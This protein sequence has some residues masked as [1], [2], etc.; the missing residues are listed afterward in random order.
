MGDLRRAR[1]SADPGLTLAPFGGSA[2]G[3]CTVV[4]GLLGFTGIAA[5][6]ATA[7]RWLFGIFLVIAIV[8]FI[9]LALGITAIF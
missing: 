7:A 1:R 5:G 4:A 6:A 9:L 8:F 2:Y 3:R